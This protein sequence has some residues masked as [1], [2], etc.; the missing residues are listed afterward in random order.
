M[1]GGHEGPT[2]SYI[3]WFGSCYVTFVS[4]QTMSQIGNVGEN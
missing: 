1:Y 3:R 2:E 4:L